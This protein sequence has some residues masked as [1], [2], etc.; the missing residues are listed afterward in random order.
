MSISFWWF[1]LILVMCRHKTLIVLAFLIYIGS[2]TFRFL[3][4]RWYI[5]HMHD[6]LH[7][8]LSVD[9]ITVPTNLMKMC[10]LL[11]YFHVCFHFHLMTCWLK[12]PD[13]S[14][15]CKISILSRSDSSHNELT[16][17]GKFVPLVGNILER[18][19]DCACFTL[20]KLE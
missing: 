11:Y 17:V 9:I 3:C 15:S 16:E 19:S 20:H 7:C 8:I 18:I 13:S 4:K 6:I 10:P 14:N 2:I 5:Q 12:S 1:F